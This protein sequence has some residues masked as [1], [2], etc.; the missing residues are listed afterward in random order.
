MHRIRTRLSR[1]D[2]VPEACDLN[3]VVQD[4]L[5]LL[6]RRLA[7]TS[8]RL[9]AQLAPDLPLLQ[10][11]RVGI[12]QVITNLVRNAADSLGAAA[13]ERN[14]RVATELRSGAVRVEVSD[15][16][17][18]LQ[19]RTIEALCASFYSTKP[20]G[21]GMG[22]AICRSIIEA[23]QGSLGASEAAGGGASFFFS[24]PITETLPTRTPA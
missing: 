23:H 14:I 18:G 13:P 1:R 19:G 2:P 17:P 21:M 6:A 16:G 10:A 3:A 5:D 7:Q 24:L 15:N 8:I 22:L 12:E 4:A 20:E 11:D 9:D